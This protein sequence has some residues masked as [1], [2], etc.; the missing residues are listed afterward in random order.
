MNDLIQEMIEYE[1][2][3][4]L[5]WLLNEWMYLN[6]WIWMMNKWIYMIE[7]ELLNMIWEWKWD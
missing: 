7:F 4:I 5:I 1:W 3:W 6:D 2:I